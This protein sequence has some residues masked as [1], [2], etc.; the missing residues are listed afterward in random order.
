M[1]CASAFV[2]TW[3]QWKSGVHRLH[4]PLKQP[5]FVFLRLESALAGCYFT[6]KSRHTC[7]LGK[8]HK[9]KQPTNKAEFCINASSIGGGT[10]ISTNNKLHRNHESIP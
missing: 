1:N 6:T 2:R 8:T 10:A 3:R 4:N 5:F 9:T 7:P